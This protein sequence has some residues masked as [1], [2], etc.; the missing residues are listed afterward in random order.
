MIRLL[1]SFVFRLS[2]SP[3]CSRVDRQADGGGVPVWFEAGFPS[4]CQVM[5]CPS[6]GLV[7]SK[8]T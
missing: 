7:A 6:A 5:L 1:N 8:L 3:D 4:V 2:S